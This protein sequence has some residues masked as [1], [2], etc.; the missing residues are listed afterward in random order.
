MAAITWTL[1]KV[2]ATRNRV[3]YAADITAGGT[4]DTKDIT[5]TGTATPDLITDTAVGTRINQVATACKFGGTAPVG[6]APATIDTQAKAEARVYGGTDPLT[7]TT[8]KPTLAVNIVKSQ[9][10][11]TAGADLSVYANT[12]GAAAVKLTVNA[13]A[14]AACRYHIEVRALPGYGR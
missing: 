6:T 13:L 3:V 2:Y 9:G 14:A 10:T 11:A 1:A 8:S 5:C 7:N 4:V 12:D